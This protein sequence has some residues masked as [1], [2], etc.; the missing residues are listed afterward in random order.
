M[1]VKY[2]RVDISAGRGLHI[3]AIFNRR[4]R[5][6]RRAAESLRMRFLQLV[7]ALAI[8]GQLERGR[9]KL[10]VVTA[11]RWR[12]SRIALRRRNAHIRVAIRES[13]HRQSDPT[14]QERVTNR[15]QRSFLVVLNNT[16]KR[17]RENEGSTAKNITSARFTLSSEL[18]RSFFLFPCVFLLELVE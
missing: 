17:P 5:S 4:V 18:F 9:V 13:E 15:A 1:S 16:R 11:V 6:V 2:S 3:K 12:V 8:Q 14:D 7:K 10:C